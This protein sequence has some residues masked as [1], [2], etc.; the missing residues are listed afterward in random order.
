MSTLVSAPFLGPSESASGST[1]NGPWVRP[2]SATCS[3]AY[4]LFRIQESHR[5]VWRYHPPLSSA[6]VWSGRSSSMH[7]LLIE[8]LPRTS[9][10]PDTPGLT[11]WMMMFSAPLSAPGSTSSSVVRVWLAL[12]VG[13][14]IIGGVSSPSLM[15]TI[16]TAFALA[17]VACR[18]L[19]YH[20]TPVFTPF[21]I[22]PL[23]LLRLFIT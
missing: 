2:W 12:P 20:C 10:S 9:P 8:P 21:I 5:H 7:M 17:V 13:T 4:L 14:L 6:A 3:V 1:N 15:L 16:L 19:V 11:P 18:C 22:V 23:C